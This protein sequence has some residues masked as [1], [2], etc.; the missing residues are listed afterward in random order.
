[1]TKAPLENWIDGKS[2]SGEDTFLMAL[3]HAAAVDIGLPCFL[4]TGHTSGKHSWRETCYV[5]DAVSIDLHVARLVEESMMG[6]PSL[7]TE[8]WAVREL[9]DTV[10]L[11][12]AFNGM[13]ITREFRYFSDGSEVSHRQAYWPPDAIVNPDQADWREAL[14]RAAFCPPPLDRDLTE[15]AMRAASVQNGGEW[16]VDMLYGSRGDWFITDMA[17]AEDSFRWEP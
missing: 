6:F 2:A 16:S 15:L 9:I 4:R 5:T 7:P 14:E 3:R 10:P 11:F 8:V 12:H 1:M 13:P 17:R